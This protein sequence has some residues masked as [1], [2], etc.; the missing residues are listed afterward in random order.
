MS[1]ITDRT[2]P[3]AWRAVAPCARSNDQCEEDRHCTRQRQSV[4]TSA[5]DMRKQKHDEYHTNPGQ[6]S[7]EH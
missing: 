6:A 2:S 7:E 3:R 1:I 5:G 4:E